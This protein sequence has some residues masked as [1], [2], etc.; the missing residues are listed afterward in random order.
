LKKMKLTMGDY[1]VYAR[2]HTDKV[3]QYIAAMEK[4]FPA[5]GLVRH[6]KICDNEWMLPMPFGIDVDEPENH[7]RPVP[8]DIGYNRMGQFF[9]SWYAPMEPLGW[10]N[11]IA[12]VD[13]KDLPEY[14]RRMKEIWTKPGATIEMD[15]VEVEA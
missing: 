6:A 9:C 11:L 12:S 10:T 2:L 13:A 7:V 1:V 5:K 14:G 3:P 15:I 4:A 8:G